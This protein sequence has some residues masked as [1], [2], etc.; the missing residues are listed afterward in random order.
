MNG[1]KAAKEKSILLLSITLVMLACLRA[2]DRVDPHFRNFKTP[3][4]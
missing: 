1:M 4:R 3:R 2:C